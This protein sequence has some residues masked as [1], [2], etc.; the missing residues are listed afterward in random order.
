MSSV[1]TVTAGRVDRS[2][3]VEVKI[4]DDLQGVRGRRALKRVRQCFEPGSIGALQRKQ[5]GDCIAPALR[6]TAAIN[7]AACVDNGSR[8][9]IF[10][11]GAK[12]GLTLGI[13]QRHFT[14][15]LAT[16]WHHPFPLRNA[17]PME[18]TDRFTG[19][20]R[21]SDTAAGWPTF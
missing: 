8:L 12:A 4:S 16:F 3:R 17:V 9:L 7:P 13:V 11:A 10:V 5:L 1:A 6:A 15:G 20:A 19:S 2:E 14:S 18:M 21:R